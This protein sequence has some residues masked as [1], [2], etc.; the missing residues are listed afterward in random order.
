MLNQ[1]GGFRV[2]DADP[3]SHSITQDPNKYQWVLRGWYNIAD[4]KYYDVTENYAIATV[5]SENLN[6]FYADWGAAP[7]NYNQT[8]NNPIQTADTS[9]FVTIGVWDYNEMYNL[10]SAKAYKVDG[11]RYLQQPRNTI[12]S[13]EWY[14][15][16]WNEYVQ[17]VDNTDS[18]NCWQYG[19]LGNKQGRG[20]HDDTYGWSNYSGM[21]PR[22]GI[23]GTVGQTT[24][25]RVLQDLFDTSNEPGT[26]VTY[27]GEA[28]YLFSYDPDRKMYSYDS[29]ENGAVYNQSEQRFY[30]ADRP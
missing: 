24:N 28:N 1:P 5:S 3:A 9:S 11:D 7:E 10:N 18:S 27:V 26:G 22:F 8:L 2:S 14:Y 15:D 13:E 25:A 6:V 23:A 20:A 21:T 19:T 12:E 17:F 29:D 30:V 4:G 16:K